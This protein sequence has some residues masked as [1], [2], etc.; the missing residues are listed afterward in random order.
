MKRMILYAACLMLAYANAIMSMDDHK[1]NPIII[2]ETTTH[3]STPKTPKVPLTPRECACC[4]LAKRQ[5]KKLPYDDAD[6]PI[7]SPTKE[8][9]RS[10]VISSDEKTQQN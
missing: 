1:P 9:T 10:L 3:P 4:L 8:P 5:C 6:H 2:P 7:T